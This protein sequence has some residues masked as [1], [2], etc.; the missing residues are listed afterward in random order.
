MPPRTEADRPQREPRPPRSRAVVVA[1]RVLATIGVV[2][3]G[4]YGYVSAET[5]LYQRQEDRQLNAILA[6]ATPA[7]APSAPRAAR[8]PAQG[9]TIGR[10]EIP[11]LDVSAVVRAGADARTLR[12]AVGHI[13]GTALPGEPGNT[14][15]AG[16]RDTF[17][18]RLQDI[19]PG[20]AIRLITPQ[21]TFVYLVERTDVVDP[22]D[23]WVLDPTADPVLTLVTCYPFTYL[24]PAPDRFVVRARI[25][26]GSQPS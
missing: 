8:P 9:S 2:C 6:S 19:R 17:F 5:F 18:R 22:D 26:Q 21:G 16:H 3:L 25:Q 14:G 1:E 12:L 15:L 23:V 7:P 13:P 10:I 24:G 11:R 4:W 20:D